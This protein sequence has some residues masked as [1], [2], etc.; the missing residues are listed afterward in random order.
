VRALSCQSA[1]WSWPVELLTCVYW[2]R[3]APFYPGRTSCLP[4]F[5][6]S[7]PLSHAFSFTPFLSLSTIPFVCL[8]LSPRLLKQYH[9]LFSSTV[10]FSNPPPPFPSVLLSAVL[11]SLF[12][13][14]FFPVFPFLL[15]FCFPSTSAPAVRFYFA[16]FSDLFVGLSGERG[17]I[18][19][20]APG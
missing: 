15:V 13:L 4:A 14:A 20:S 2:T 1:R 19:F 18:F 8:A 12:F 7:L 3:P 10:I 6:F 17:A 9:F 5:P 11:Y 16:L